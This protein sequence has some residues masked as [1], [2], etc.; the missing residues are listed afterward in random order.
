[1][2]LHSVT[3][4]VAR[5]VHNDPV[6]LMPVGDIQYAGK[7]SS[8]AVT[9]LTKHIAWG[10]A[11]NA[12]F[13]GM[14]DYVDFASPSNRLRLAQAA[15]YDTATKTIGDAARALTLDLYKTALQGS[16]GRWLGLL[17]GHHYYPFADGT[18]TDQL[19]C[20]R[21]K[22]RF[23][24]TSAYVRLMF[25]RGTRWGS[26]L[27]WCHHGTG[28]GAR[29]SAPLNKLDQLLSNWEADI[30]LMGHQSK[31][32]SAPIDRIEPVWR[33]RGEPRLI[34]RTKI[35]ACT[36]SF[37]RAYM[38]GNRQ[39]S[40]PRGDYVEQ[41]MLPPTA[42]GGVVIRITPRW[43]RQNGSRNPLWL[44]DLSVEV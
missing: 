17:E 42:L 43:I 24:G 6:L 28:Y 14:G 9:M 21:L 5:T 30:Y 27:I 3:I 4:P 19:L 1:V 44:P 38:V 22:T 20:Q 32:V 33:G 37:S 15:L 40:V 10:V 36:G 31:K 23:L 7:D 2:E 26:V 12:Y 29:A 25:Q 16:E 13:L 34:H 39:G 11:H 18:T 8:T 35:L 41:K